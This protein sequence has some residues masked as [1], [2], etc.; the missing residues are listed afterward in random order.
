[1]ENH[2]SDAPKDTEIDA[3]LPPVRPD[4][5]S[6]PNPGPAPSLSW[7]AGTWALLMVSGVLGFLPWLA[8]VGELVLLP[9]LERQYRDFGIKLPLLTE[10]V[11]RHSRWA[12]PTLTLAALLVC[13][14][15][16][17][18]SPWL[19]VF[20]LLLLPLVLNLVVGV[21]L[22]FPYMVLLDGLGGGKK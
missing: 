18:R 5:D 6:S 14:G 13:I 11:L 19:W 9:R 17:S 2:V 12:V 4:R 8:V 20:L 21:G 15:L 1:M 10:M 3:G 7:S 22:F 16:G